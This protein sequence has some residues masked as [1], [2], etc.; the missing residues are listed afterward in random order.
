MKHTQKFDSIKECIQF[1]IGVQGVVYLDKLTV[2]W[3]SKSPKSD[4]VKDWALANGYTVF[5]IDL[6]DKEPIDFGGIPFPIN[7]DD[8]EALNIKNHNKMRGK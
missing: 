3:Y 4:L 7:P 5:H 8:V 6:S 2:E 1:A